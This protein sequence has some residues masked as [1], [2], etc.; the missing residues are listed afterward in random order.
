MIDPAGNVYISDA[1]NNRIRKVT[2]T[3]IIYTIAGNG[4]PG[5]SGDGG[6][7]TAAEFHNPSGLAMDGAGNL[8][9]ADYYNNVVRKVSAATGRI[10]TVVGI[11]AA[12]SFGGD[13]GAAT[14]AHLFYPY[15]LTFD[16]YGNLYI[17]DCD[18]DVIRKVA[19]T[20]DSIVGSDII[21]TFAGH[22]GVSG[23]TGDGGAATLAYFHN[24][25]NIYMDPYNNLYISDNGNQRIRKVNTSN[26]VSTVAGTGVLGYSGDGFAAT[27]AELTYP[28]GMK[29]DQLG[30]LYFCDA[31]N[32]RI[33]KVNS[34][35][36]ISTICGT[37]TAGTSADGTPATAAMMSEPL[38]IAIDHPGN[39]YYADYGNNQIRVILSGKAAP[40]FVNGHYQTLNICENA[41][42]DS[43]NS[44]LVINDTDR[45][46]TDTWYLRYGPFNGTAYVAYS[47]TSGSSS[48][49]PVGM[50]Y[51][52]NANYSGPDSF[53]VWVNN[54]FGLDSTTIRV[55]VKSFYA[56]LITPEPAIVCPGYTVQLSD[57]TTGGTWT[58]NALPGIATISASGLVTGEAAG[59]A[60][61]SYT[62]TNSCGTT[63]SMAEVIV[64]DPIIN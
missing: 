5:Y 6:A 10:S 46:L 43:V 57:D 23:T 53:Q 16:S 64:G 29:T 1:N 28:A 22:G 50:Y 4:T 36:I 12:G 40:A 20:T 61:V 2:T 48:I 62:I 60:R 45:G 59:N 33:R 52:P 19:A 38:D 26:I 37:G 58:L 27:T 17:S 34:A 44:L 49:T 18:N 7:A 9:V 30:N 63:S 41:S 14:A 25:N 24:P 11:N 3:G 42:P 54:G 55:N 31:V 13:G 32:N 15:G 51:V 21:T 35:G 56:G 8:Y 47:A 39:I